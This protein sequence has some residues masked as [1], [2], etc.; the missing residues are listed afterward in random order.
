M[1]REISREPQ[2]HYD[3]P[4]CCLNYA[5]EDF[6]AYY[7]ITGEIWLNGTGSCM[8]PYS[9]GPL[10]VVFRLHHSLCYVSGKEY[11]DVIEEFY[12]KTPCLE[13]A[14]FLF[15][16]ASGGNIAKEVP[17]DLDALAKGY[18]DFDAALAPLGE[19]LDVLMDL[20][21]VIAAFVDAQTKL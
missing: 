1:T 14:G 15:S 7:A 2:M 6:F 3:D 21:V 12:R 4:G 10:W 16:P 19:A 17:L 11:E 5:T 8:P 13:E 18:P 9:M 20:H